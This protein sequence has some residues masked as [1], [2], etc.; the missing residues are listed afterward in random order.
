[1]VLKKVKVAAFRSIRTECDVVIDAKVT[2][3]LGANDHGK[4]NLLFAISH[5]NEDNPF[6]QDDLNW[7]TPQVADGPSRVPA[8]SAEFEL[9]KLEIES[10]SQIINDFEEDET[11]SEA[12]ADDSTPG[13]QVETTT[14][15]ELSDSQ[16]PAANQTG[17]AGEHTYNE[18]LGPRVRFAR[19][20]IPGD[21]FLNGF[22]ILSLPEAIQDWLVANL[23]R[24]E[25]FEGF[26]GGLQDETD[27][28][29]LKL[30]DSEFIQ[31][32]FYHAGIEQNEWKDIFTH[33]DVTTKRLA[34]ASSVLN[35]H[36]QQMW[37]QGQQMT[38]KLQHKGEGGKSTIELR[39]DDPAVENRVVRLSS[40][41]TG[42][43]HFFRL[44]MMLHARKMKNPANHYIFLFDEPGLHLH[45][46]GERDLLRAFE[47]LT[48]SFQIIMVTHSLFMLNANYPERYR[49]V[50]MG[51]KGTEIDHKPYKSSWKLATDAF[52]VRVGSMALFSNRTLLVEGESDPM[53]LYELVR[54][55]N[56]RNVTQADINQLGII[57]F[58]NHPTLRYLL[59]LLS[60][61]PGQASVAVLLDG[62]KSGKITGNLIAE[63]RR[64]NKIGVLYLSDG[65][66]IE[67]LCLFRKTLSKAISET[68]SDACVAEGRQVPGD[69]LAKVSKALESYYA[70]GLVLGDKP[71][72]P[73]TL[74][75]LFKKLSKSIIEAASQ[76][77][78]EAPSEPASP[79]SEA[80]LEVPSAPSEEHSEEKGASKVALAR[81]Y[82]E[83]CRAQDDPSFEEEKE[84][85]DAETLK[86][87]SRVIKEIV[88]AL[89]LPS[90]RADRGVIV[91]SPRP[92]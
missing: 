12:T 22:P 45:P 14:K 55:L 78:V 19:M 1:M 20:G 47:T 44:S 36:L 21:L 60:A 33:S 82:V 90:Q 54:Q 41:S 79:P 35:S 27:A 64:A 46:L 65:H 25:L 75:Q 70:D 10:L 30:P 77:I 91:E 38:F 40:K 11:D 59:Q 17:R 31:G 81:R 28:D 53:Y 86:H 71:K 29:S 24:F 56:V 49:L 52:G 69:V 9:G 76:S 18:L 37:G 16:K 26:S 43:T 62:D 61:E 34:K 5:L 84:V 51:E 15:P 32:I 74:G 68:V 80:P 23:P 50:F 6:S 72:M 3:M 87:A 73:A 8:V 48:E 67:N 83:M 66:S 39:V 13:P 2:T 58:S 63:L 7:D 42:V 92:A 57:S 4:S 89:E 85:Y 88:E